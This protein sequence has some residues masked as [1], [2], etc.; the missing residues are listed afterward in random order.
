M[1]YSRHRRAIE[2]MYT[3]RVSVYRHESIKDPITKETKLV[4]VTIYEDRPCRISQTGLG[5]NDQSEAQNDI[6]YESKLFIAPELEL[7]Q[8][9]MLEVTRQTVTRK[10]TTGE[11]FTY[12]THQ[13]ISL[14]RKEW[15]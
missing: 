13:E 6:E 2:K 3:D 1:I 7:Q 4:P 11:P 8:G 14:Q 12:S 5:R 10:Y 15:A 9:D